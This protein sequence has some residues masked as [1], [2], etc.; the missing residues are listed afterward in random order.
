MVAD[1]DQLRMRVDS[2]QRVIAD[3]GARLAKGKVHPRIVEQ[4]TR[5]DELLRLIDHRA[6][7]EG[8][9]GRIE[10]ATNQLMG[11]LSGLFSYQSLGEV[12]EGTRH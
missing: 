11:E 12:Y 1:L 6:V 2:C 8:D 10:E 7:T 9:L 5:L 4:L 3:V